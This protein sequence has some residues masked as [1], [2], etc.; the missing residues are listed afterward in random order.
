MKVCVNPSCAHRVGTG[1]PASFRDDVAR[2]SDCGDALSPEDAATE[3]A[4]GA[5]A[6]PKPWRA[7]LLTMALGVAPVL[8]RELPLPGA[9]PDALSEGAGRTWAALPTTLHPVNAVAAS[10]TLVTLVAA[11]SSRW[12]RLRMGPENL[13][14]L[15]RRAWVVRKS[16][17]FASGFSIAAASPSPA[18]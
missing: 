18:R 14:R 6:P 13:A 11:R 12:N 3:A 17:T 4:P 1:S 9:S 8:A 15:T 5:K 16:T 7:L 2:C 10:M